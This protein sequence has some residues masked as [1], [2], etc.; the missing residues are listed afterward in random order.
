MSVDWYD[1]EGNPISIQEANELLGDMDARRVVSTDIGPYLVSTVFL[2]LDH[3]YLPDSPP[4]LY[5]TMVFSVDM[6]D[7]PEENG[8]LE[9]DVHR[10]H[11]EQE[12]LQ[13][14]EEVC[15]LVRATLD[16]NVPQIAPEAAGGQTEGPDVA[17]Y[18][19]YH[20]LNSL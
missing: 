5:E 20:A 11:T 3:G 17:Y 9:F 16:E 13:G 6:R 15:L 2:V 4:V 18:L 8:L 7:D 19:A 10:Y 1:R 12:A 14:H